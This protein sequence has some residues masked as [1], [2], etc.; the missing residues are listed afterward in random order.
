MIKLPE[1]NEHLCLNCYRS[2]PHTPRFDRY[3]W[4]I[5]TCEECEEET[6]I[7]LNAYLDSRGLSIT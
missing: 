6:H 7:E 2:T 1:V 5:L 3:N 4:L